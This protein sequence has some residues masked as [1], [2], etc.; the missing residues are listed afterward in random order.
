MKWSDRNPH[1]KCYYSPDALTNPYITISGSDHGLASVY[2]KWNINQMKG[3]ISDKLSSFP[4][5]ASIVKC[6]K[7]MGN[8]I[9]DSVRPGRM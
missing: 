3:L 9:S 8:R 4:K 5:P 7:K 2:H 1:L 6:K